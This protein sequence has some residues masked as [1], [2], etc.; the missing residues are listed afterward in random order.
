MFEKFIDG[1]YDDEEEEYYHRC[2]YCGRY[3]KSDSGCSNG[4]YTC[5]D[6]CLDEL[7]ADD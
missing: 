7:I 1:G 5:C 6:D 4:S 3:F 2:D